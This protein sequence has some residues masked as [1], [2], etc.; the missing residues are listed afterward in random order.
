MAWKID[1]ERKQKGDVNLNRFTEVYRQ[2]VPPPNTRN[3]YANNSF[4]VFCMQRDFMYDQCLWLFGD[5][6]NL[7]F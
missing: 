1:D 2:V 4:I 7:K 5:P 6:Y 3:F